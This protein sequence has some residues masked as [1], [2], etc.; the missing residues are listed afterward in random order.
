M[1]TQHP[2]VSQ[3]TKE[4]PLGVETVLKQVF[5]DTSEITVETRRDIETFRK[6]GTSREGLLMHIGLHLAPFP[7]R[8]SAI[9]NEWHRLLFYLPFAGPYLA[10]AEWL[11]RKQKDFAERERYNQAL[12]DLARTMGTQTSLKA[13]CES[14]L[15]LKNRYEKDEPP[16]S[17]QR[18][19]ESPPPPSGS[20]KRWFFI[21]WSKTKIRCT[22]RRKR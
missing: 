21:S 15:A 3:N 10:R 7:P 13:G 5:T 1:L 14:F 11:W 17:H 16:R 2:W 22:W 6:T 8:A 4:T 12:C 19:P 9:T 18:G 20:W